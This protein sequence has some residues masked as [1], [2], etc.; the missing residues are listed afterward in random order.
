MKNLLALVIV[1]CAMPAMATVTYVQGSVGTGSLNVST[2]AMGSNV[3]AGDL[4]VVTSKVASTATGATLAISDTTGATWTNLTPVWNNATAGFSSSVGWAIAGS[5][6][7]DTVTVT[8]SGGTLAGFVDCTVAEYG[9]TLG[10]NSSTLDVST[11]AFS[12]T[13]GTSCA[14]GTSAAT[15]NAN[16]LVIGVCFNFNVA[17]TYGSVAGYTFESASSRNTTGFYDQPVTSTGTQSITVP[18]TSDTWT[19]FVVAL[20]QTAPAA[21]VTRGKAVI[22]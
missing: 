1:L 8:W 13:A 7:A 12:A 16:D 21:A 14:S 4:L 5:T 11:S 19:S 6:A 22:F 3:T 17:Q 2:C 18:V 10:W 15:T 9:S 20:K